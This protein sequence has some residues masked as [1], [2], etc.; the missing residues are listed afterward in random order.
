MVEKNVHNHNFFSCFITTVICYFESEKEE[1]AAVYTCY[2][3]TVL[4]N[5]SCGFLKSSHTARNE[6]LIADTVTAEMKPMSAAS[7]FILSLLRSSVFYRLL[8]SFFITNNVLQSVC[9]FW[10]DD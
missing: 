10:H 6:V 2:Q 1:A 3:K 5:L 8:Q 7:I 9:C 4:L